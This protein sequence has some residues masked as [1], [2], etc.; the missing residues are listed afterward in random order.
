[1]IASFFNEI[2]LYKT[3]LRKGKIENPR[4]RKFYEKVQE[5]DKI[6]DTGG[7]AVTE[8]RSAFWIE[9]CE[10][11]IA[12]RIAK[13]LGRKPVTGI[14]CGR[15]HAGPNERFILSEE[16]RRKIIDNFNIDIK[17]FPKFSRFILDYEQSAFVIDKKEIPDLT[18]KRIS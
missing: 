2:L 3:K 6:I 12:I 9:R 16:D 4:I 5:I 14:V 1:M 11:N 13:E 18:R 8:L 17:R 15:A 10:K 7:W